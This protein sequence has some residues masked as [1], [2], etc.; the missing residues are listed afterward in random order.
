MTHSTTAAQPLDL[1]SLRFDHRGA[2]MVPDPTG[3]YILVPDVRALIAQARAAQPKREMPPEMKAA[4]EEAH[5]TGATGALLPNGS[6]V[7]INYGHDYGDNDHLCC[8]ACGGS[9]H[10]EDQQVRASQRESDTGTTGAVQNDDDEFLELPKQPEE[11]R[12]RWKC[13]DCDGRGHD[14]ESHWQGHFQP[15]EPAKCSACDGSGW[16]DVVALLP[17]QVIEAQRKARDYQK[18]VDRKIIDRRDAEIADLRAQLAAKGQ[19]EFPSGALHNGE[20]YADRLENIY[21]FECEAG[22]L[23][24]CTEWVELRRCMRYIADYLAASAS[25]QPDRGAAQGDERALFNET[26]QR[27]AEQVYAMRLPDAESEDQALF[28]LWKDGQSKAAAAASPAS[29]PVAPDDWKVVPIQPTK[30]MMDAARLAWCITPGNAIEESYAAMWR[31]APVAAVA[32]SD[33]KGKADDADAVVLPLELAQRCLSS[34]KQAVAF[35]ETGKGRP[36]S[37]TCLFEIEELEAILKGQPHID[38]T[39]K[40][41]A[42]NAG[43][44]SERDGWEAAIKALQGRA[45]GHRRNK[46]TY[47]YDEC[48]QC[49]AMLNDMK[50]ADSQSP[51]TS[52]ADAKDA[53]R[54]RVLRDSDYQMLEDDPCVSDACFN[55]YFGDDLDKAVDELKARRDAAI[56]AAQQGGA[57]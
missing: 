40:A 37:Q 19:G 20:V 15:P 29:Q 21:D 18:K 10:I 36:P 5:K 32:P 35:G 7:F 56:A 1:D 6:A 31:A 8:T 51:T 17:E 30:E 33:A 11:L 53:E 23:R 28:L 25:A 55:T 50:P 43:G 14:G 26:R 54:Y 41:D 39:G 42:A 34:M 13:E 16:V 24:N 9:G 22:P 27:I 47:L 3:D 46:S 52:A 45:L 49:V 4:I 12:A 57:K 38:A 44:P 48:M 2:L